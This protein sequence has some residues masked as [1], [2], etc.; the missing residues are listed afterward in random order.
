MESKLVLDHSLMYFAHRIEITDCDTRSFKAFLGF[1]YSRKVF[2][3]DISLDLL[4]VAEK[5]FE[6]ELKKICIDKLK[7]EISL[8]NLLDTVQAA[9]CCNSEE[10]TTACQKFVVQNY[11][12]MIGTPQLEALLPN[13]TFFSS[14]F[15]QADTVAKSL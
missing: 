11:T 13:T 1:L 15:K 4:M 10:L 2:L 5:Y 9:T 3:E 14:L 12:N 8:E 6:T 7:D